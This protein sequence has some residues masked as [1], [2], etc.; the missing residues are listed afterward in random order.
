MVRLA[1]ILR[2]AVLTIVVLA[3]EPGTGSDVTT[4]SESPG[5]PPPS[6]APTLIG[7]SLPVVTSLP[8]PGSGDRT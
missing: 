5:S 2:S 3:P 7:D 8:A 1:Y 4:G 6:E